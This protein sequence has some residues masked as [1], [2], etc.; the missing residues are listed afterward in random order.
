MAATILSVASGDCE[1]P[2]ELRLDLRD[3]KIWVGQCTSK[4]RL[5]TAVTLNIV[6][7]LNLLL[8]ILWIIHPSI[9]QTYTLRNSMFMANARTSQR[10][11]PC[12]RLV[13]S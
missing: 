6:K 11:G 12:L 9:C 7:Y 3:V 13:P 5:N 10:S 2:S 1:T 8:N 4:N